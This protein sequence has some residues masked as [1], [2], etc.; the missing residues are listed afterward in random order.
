[1]FCSKCGKEV[2]DNDSYCPSCGNKLG[3]GNQEVKISLDFSQIKKYFNDFE[4]R[5]LIYK[6]IYL[7]LVFLM[8]K[9]SQKIMFNIGDYS[10]MSIA[11]LMNDLF[12][13]KQIGGDS[14]FFARLVYKCF[15]F[16]FLGYIMAIIL[17]FIQKEELAV[18]FSK[19][20]CFLRLPMLCFAPRATFLVMRSWLFRTVHASDAIEALNGEFW[21]FIVLHIT[22]FVCG[23]YFFNNVNLSRQYNAKPHPLLN[24]D[25]VGTRKHESGEWRCSE[26]GK[27]NAEYVHTC[28]CGNSNEIK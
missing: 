3:G 11:G 5:W 24:Q 7:I 14:D 8:W 15:E 23:I 26:C 28:S 20:G 21:F 19:W 9:Q 17:A 4:K 16:G 6:I 10:R 27:I 22:I 1:M 25:I 13:L 12:T 2:N 18:I